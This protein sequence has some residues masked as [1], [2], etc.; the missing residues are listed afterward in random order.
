MSQYHDDLKNS[1]AAQGYGLSRAE[2]EHMSR[3]RQAALEMDRLNSADPAKLARLELQMRSLKDWLRD[4]QR[5]LPAI[6]REE[7]R[8]VLAEELRPA[9]EHL[10]SLR[11]GNNGRSRH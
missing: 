1:S 7:V 4:L 3:Y 11:E 5:S 8:A 6:I 2:R 9:I 10:L